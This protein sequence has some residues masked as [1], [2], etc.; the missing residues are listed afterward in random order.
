MFLRYRVDFLK[1]ELLLD[2]ETVEDDLVTVAFEGY[3]AHSFEHVMADSIL[4][5]IEEVDLS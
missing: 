1:R 4:Y 5:D 3:L 2:I